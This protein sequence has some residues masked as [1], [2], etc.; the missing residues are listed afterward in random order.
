[1]RKKTALEGGAQFPL[2]NRLY[3]LTWIVTWF[4]LC[5]WT[6]RQLDFWRRWVLTLFGATMGERSDVRATARVWNPRNLIM[7]ERTLIGPGVNCYNVAKVTVKRGA[8][9][10]QRTH[11]CTASHDV[12]NPAFP[13]VFRD[14]EVGENAWIAAEAFVGPGVSIGANAVLGA[15]ACA[16]R[17]IPIGEVHSGNPAQ[18]IRDRKLGA[19]SP[20]HKSDTPSQAR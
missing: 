6:P 19:K 1:M 17:D 12:D 20:A 16:F 15:R 8:I 14:I 13:L 10:S 5:R 11:L 9:V 3:R 18:K 4:V 7:E 2:S